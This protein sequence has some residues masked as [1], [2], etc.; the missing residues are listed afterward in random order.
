MKIHP[1]RP[2]LLV[3]IQPLLQPNRLRRLPILQKVV[4]VPIPILNL[5]LP[6]QRGFIVIY[7]AVRVN[8][9]LSGP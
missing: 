8:S 7:L 9:R 2:L 4:K 6:E 5:A 1:V 3:L